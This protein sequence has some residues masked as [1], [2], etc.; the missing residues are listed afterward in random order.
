M[1][2][3]QCPERAKSVAILGT[4]GYPSYYGGFETAVRNIV[5]SFISNGWNVRVYSRRKS[6]W[7]EDPHR[8]LEVESV[9]VPCF[10][11]G[12]LETLSHGLFS[13][14]HLVRH[15]PSVVLIMNVANGF[16][17]PIL[18]IYKIRTVVNVDG[19]EWQRGKWGPVARFV[20]RVGA[21]LTK[22]YA[23]ELVYDAI[24]VKDIWEESS[25]DL[26]GSFIPYGG[27]VLIE[28]PKISF[29]L[30]E[31]SYLLYVARLVP[32]NSIEFFLQIAEQF[33]DTLP[34]VIVGTTVD[35]LHLEMK[36]RKLS[37]SHDNFKWLG[38][39]T[40]DQTLDSLWYH[41]GVY[42]HGHTVGGTNPALVQAMA[43]GATILAQDTVF[44]REVLGDSG[45]FTDGRLEDAVTKIN[46]LLNHELDADKL[47]LK[48]I[49]R[50]KSKYNWTL[51]AKEY[52]RVFER[53]SN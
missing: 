49:N 50:V 44:N 15:K 7:K 53:L 42:F 36:L 27:N 32:E 21:R 18:K 28:K 26:Q 33:V 34:I 51:I 45:L 25:K 38:H 2:N 39:I 13:T 5:S 12:Y 9:I 30:E 41:A 24:A 43:C 40:D 31:K 52:M 29:E 35:D 14:L 47:K 4:R 48:A 20:F 8:N 22:K 17:L 16:W 6:V 3:Q 37:A 1:N 46:F 10:H 23:D 11:H 19:I